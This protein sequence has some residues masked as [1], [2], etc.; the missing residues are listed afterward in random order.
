MNG[1]VRN[2]SKNAIQ[3]MILTLNTA[4]TAAKDAA[5]PANGFR[6]TEELSE[7]HALPEL[8]S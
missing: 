4:E 5:S 3:G 1:V 8:L 6:P 2:P 7:G